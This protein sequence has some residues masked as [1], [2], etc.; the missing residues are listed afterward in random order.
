M[1]KIAAA[2]CVGALG[3]MALNDVASAGGPASNTKVDKKQYQQAAQTPNYVSQ[4]YQTLVNMGVDASRAARIAQSY[5]NYPMGAGYAQDYAYGGAVDVGNQAVLY[6]PVV[7][8]SAPA[9]VATGTAVAAEA[10][11]AASL[12]SLA[13]QARAAQAALVAAQAWLAQYFP[14]TI[15]T[16]IHMTDSA[17]AQFLNLYSQMVGLAQQA[18]A[19]LNAA[20]Q[21][22]Y[23][24]GGTVNPL[25]G[26]G[27]SQAGAAATSTLPALAGGAATAAAAWWATSG[28][29][30]SSPPGYN[31]INSPTLNTTGPS[32]PPGY[33][34]TGTISD[35][36]G[37]YGP[38]PSPPNTGPPN[39]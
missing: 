14:N 21:A 10:S 12:E 28:G 23:A 39:G 7:V 26:P 6:A 36:P 18:E 3:L 34:G 35:S 31:G 11:G 30:P 8:V 27:V 16:T 32:S 4:N 20:L 13:A 38:P 19:N 5:G 22:Y 15:A 1:R 25:A 2:V 17:R 24:A 33:N 29:Q 9:V 37:G